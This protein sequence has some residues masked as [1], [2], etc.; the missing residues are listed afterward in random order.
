M[1]PAL[2]SK[3][4]IDINNTA[5]KT[6]WSDLDIGDQLLL[7]RPGMT[8]RHRKYYWRGATDGWQML[9]SGGG[10]E[11]VEIEICPGDAFMIYR[12]ANESLTWEVAL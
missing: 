8:P 4:C 2:F 10:F 7:Y 6:G 9:K 11:A 5:M 12:R 1:L 3:G